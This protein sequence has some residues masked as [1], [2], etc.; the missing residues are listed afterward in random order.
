[1]AS[2]VIFSARSHMG[3]V[4][5]N[6]EDNLY[7]AGVTLTPE[8][9][10]APFVMDGE[11]QAP[12]LFAVC[13]GMGG[14]ARGE[15]ASWVAVN[16][17]GELEA[18]VKS[19]PPG[20]PDA[21]VQ[22][23]VT[24]VNRQLCDEMRK[25][26]LRIGTTLALVVIQGNKVYPYNIGDSR[27]Y[28]LAEG[29]ISQISHEHTMAAQKVKMGFLTEEQAKKDPDRHKLTLHLGIPDDEMTLMAEAARPLSPKHPLRL[30]L[31][32]DGLTDFVSDD[33][34]A[35][36]LNDNSA[37]EAATLLLDEALRNG[38]KDNITCIVLQVDPSSDGETMGA[39][40][41][42]AQ[43]FSLVAKRIGKR[44]V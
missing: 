31:C 1:M 9:R 11:T 12:C 14:H 44:R 4:R 6:N 41:I 24:R 20:E 40:G 32:S 26:N 15:F 21:L 43:F 37:G 23:Y 5:T 2:H 35:E 13:D 18:A 42:V 27:I 3:K 8:N 22:E 38:G 16:G 17:L 33:R 39:K 19:A 25:K 36:I 7:C 28:A 30:L 34:I 29:E 10:D